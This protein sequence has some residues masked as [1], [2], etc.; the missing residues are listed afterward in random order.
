MAV[1]DRTGISPVE[2]WQLTPT[3]I[4]RVAKVRNELAAEEFK[5]QLTLHYTGAK[6][7]RAKK[8]PPLA[9]LT[10]E[11]RPSSFREIVSRVQSAPTFTPHQ[12]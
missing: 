10:G 4:F 2:V 11:K 12:D 8:I 3:E 9:K 6:L 5:Q 1:A 7:Q